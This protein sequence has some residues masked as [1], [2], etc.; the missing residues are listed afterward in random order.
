MNIKHKSK[1][2]EVKI[3]LYHFGS[4]KENEPF[5]FPVC[6]LYIPCKLQTKNLG[7]CKKNE[8]N[9]YIDIIDYIKNT[10]K[11]IDFFVLPKK[12]SID[13]LK[14]NHAYIYYLYADI[15]TFN[16]TDGNFA[17]L[18][19]K[20]EL[21][22]SKMGGHDILLRLVHEP[23]DMFR[24]ANNTFSLVITD[25]NNIY[26]KLFD[27]QIITYYP[28]ENNYQCMNSKELHEQEMCKKNN[29][30]SLEKVVN[31]IIK[32]HLKSKK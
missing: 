20:K 22:T 14:K 21:L 10:N 27:R 6:S 25:P 23:N 3:P 16:T 1:D 12:V 8:D 32:S 17:P 5:A 11:R 9:L 2:G 31:S 15:D 29:D 28:N 26:G 24:E 4:I 18:S 13:Q 7:D 19:N 30:N